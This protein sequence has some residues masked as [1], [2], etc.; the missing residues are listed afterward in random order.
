MEGLE[1]LLA[2]ALAELESHKV[3][4]D[5]PLMTRSTE[6]L[7]ELESRLMTFDGAHRRARF[8]P[9]DGRQA[10]QARPPVD[11]AEHGA[12]GDDL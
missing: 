10:R 11:A 4:A 5:W 9:P 8:S 3:C 12:A 1:K 7:A 2:E 6:R